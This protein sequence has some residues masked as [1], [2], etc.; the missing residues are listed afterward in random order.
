MKKQTHTL[1]DTIRYSFDYEHFRVDQD[2][3][4]WLRYTRHTPGVDALSTEQQAH[5]N[6]YRKKIK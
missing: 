1:Q 2:S 6:Q 3:N 4:L 5:S